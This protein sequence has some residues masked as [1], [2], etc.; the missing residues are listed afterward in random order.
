MAAHIAGVPPL[1]ASDRV[2]PAGNEAD[3]AGAAGKG[4]AFTTPTGVGAGTAVVGGAVAGGAL[5]VA[6]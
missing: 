4:M 1:R 6:A 2:P 3:V 5:A